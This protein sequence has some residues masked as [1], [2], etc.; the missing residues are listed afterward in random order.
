MLPSLYTIL[1]YG[2]AISVLI[3]FIASVLNLK[4]FNSQLR[5]LFVFLFVAGITESLSYYLM[6]QRRSNESLYFIYTIVEGL[7]IIALFYFELRR[8]ITSIVL[9]I[10]LVFSAII[11][12]ISWSNDTGFLNIVEALIAIFLSV[13]YFHSIFLDLNIRFLERHYFFWINAAFLFYF[14]ITLF[15]HLFE[16]FIRQ[17]SHRIEEFWGINLVTTIL[18][19]VVLAWGILK[20]K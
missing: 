8:P 19:N 12:K 15:V 16:N 10:L 17:G 14:S 18:F 13:S 7:L 5:V 20:K 11:S 3:P 1:E 9:S 6:T 4:A 2:S